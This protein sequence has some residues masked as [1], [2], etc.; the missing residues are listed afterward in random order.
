MHL[1]LLIFLVIKNITPTYYNDT[2]AQDSG[3]FVYIN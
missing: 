3:Q 2:K 1:T